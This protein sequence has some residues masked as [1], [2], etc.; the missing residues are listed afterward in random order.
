VVVGVECRGIVNSNL[1]RQIRFRV[2]EGARFHL[3]GTIYDAGEE[4]TLPF[5]EAAKVLRKAK[6]GVEVVEVIEDE[7]ERLP[8]ERKPP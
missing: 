3:G 2:R 7:A 1:T 4:F 5:H 8:P 6:T